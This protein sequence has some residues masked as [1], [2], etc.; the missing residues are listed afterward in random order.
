MIIRSHGGRTDSTVTLSHA[1]TGT[2]GPNPRASVGPMTRRPMRDG[3]SSSLK[4]TFSPGA[5]L[6]ISYVFL[7]SRSSTL[8]FVTVTMPVFVTSLVSTIGVN[9]AI[10]IDGWPLTSFC[11]FSA[12]SA[13]ETH[14]AGGG[15][16]WTGGGT[17]GNGGT[18]GSCS[19]SG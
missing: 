18:V 15:S 13:F 5:R 4:V 9:G 12:G 7:S 6:L 11:T 2:C 10:L 14:S 3:R 8:T 1:R 16:S 19:F 17:G